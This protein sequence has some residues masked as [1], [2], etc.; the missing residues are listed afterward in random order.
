MNPRAQERLLFAVSTHWVKYIRRFILSHFLLTCGIILFFVAY[1]AKNAPQIVS[2]TTCVLGIT[3]ILFAHHLFFHLLM[4]EA[5]LDIVITTDRIIYFNDSLFVCDDE[6]EIPLN[7]IAGVEVQQ[8]GLIQNI[9]N[10]GI[11]WIDKGGGSI[12]LKRSIPN[13][14]QPEQIGRIMSQA[15]SQKAD[16]M[17]E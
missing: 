13:V 12:D 7:K 5:L 17:D 1:A 3:F 14:P 15:V 8:H 9:L 16:A 2:L 10:Y 11:V 6:H 4:S